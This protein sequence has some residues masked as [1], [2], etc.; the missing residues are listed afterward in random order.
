MYYILS[1]EILT[2]SLD[3]ETYFGSMKRMKAWVCRRTKDIGWNQEHLACCEPCCVYFNNVLP[4][5]T[6]YLHTGHHHLRI[7]S[8]KWITL[9]GLLFSELIGKYFSN[10]KIK[11]TLLK[12]VSNLWSSV[13]SYRNVLISFMRY[14]IWASRCLFKLYVILYIPTRILLL[15][16]LGYNQSWRWGQYVPPKRR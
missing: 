11:L 7:D 16:D 5:G 8:V 4:W 13:I 2:K 3:S 10:L 14:C 12:P 15:A 1:R 6:K 9:C